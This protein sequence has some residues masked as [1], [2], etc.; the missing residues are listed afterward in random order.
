MPDVATFYQRYINGRDSLPY[1]A[2][3][4]K[5][6]VDYHVEHTTVPTLG[7]STSGANFA[8]LTGVTPGS[9]AAAAGLQAGDT[10]VRIGDVVAS[11]TAD[12]G[13]EF[14]SRY[15]GKGGSALDIVVHRGAQQLTLHATVR[16]REVESIHVD[17][18]KSPTPKQARI[19]HGLAT[20]TTGR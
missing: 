4:A 16:E 20:G 14:R 9:V 11:T 15:H 19:W 8:V 18:V 3:F 7:V 6:G 17:L 2:V 12:F 10:L 13:P 1:A 5:A